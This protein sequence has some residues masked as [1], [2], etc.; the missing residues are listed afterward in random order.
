MLLRCINFQMIS[1]NSLS[2][3][4]MSFLPP[5][6]IFG[7]TTRRSLFR[8]SWLNTRHIRCLSRMAEAH[9]EFLAKQ[10]TEAVPITKPSFESLALGT[11][12]IRALQRAYPNVKAPTD[13]QAQLIP[14]ILGT[15]DILLRDV[16]GCGKC[17][18]SFYFISRCLFSTCSGPGRLG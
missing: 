7:R 10:T 15:Q 9:S 1:S 18:F 12:F 14:A 3:D 11:A 4:S 2:R 5:S 17:V 8:W 6:T 13:T 16:T